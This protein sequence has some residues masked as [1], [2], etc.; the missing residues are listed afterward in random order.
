MHDSMSSL[1]GLVSPFYGRRRGCESQQDRKFCPIHD[2]LTCAVYRHSIA[3]AFG[4]KLLLADGTA[5]KTL[6]LVFAA[7]DSGCVFLLPIVVPCCGR[8]NACVR[9]RSAGKNCGVG[10][11]VEVETFENCDKDARRHAKQ[12]RE[13][14]GSECL[15]KRQWI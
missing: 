4:Y 15:E 10:E 7:A 1:S 6:T 12:Q 3:R 14:T 5:L 11:Q 9:S 8:P 13:P 2:W